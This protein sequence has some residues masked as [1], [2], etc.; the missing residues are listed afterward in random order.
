MIGH[1]RFV[2]SWSVL[3]VK[4][5]DEGWLFTNP[6]IISDTQVVDWINQSFPNATDSVK[7]NIEAYYPSPIQALSRYST[8]FGRV[9]NIIA[10]T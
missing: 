6:L 1:N 7:K 2:I 8:E 10:G 5:S 3:T 9:E 4:F